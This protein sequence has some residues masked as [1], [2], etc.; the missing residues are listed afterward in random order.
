MTKILFRSTNAKF[1]HIL[2][3]QL[4]QDLGHAELDTDLQINPCVTQADEQAT[5]GDPI[6]WTM[7]ALTAAGA[8]GA[9]TAL[10]GRDGFLEDPQ[11][12]PH[13]DATARVGLVEITPTVEDK[14]YFV[15]NLLDNALTEE[16]SDA[17]RQQLAGKASRY[18]YQLTQ[19]SRPEAL[20]LEIVL[21][22]PFSVAGAGTGCCG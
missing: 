20:G 11:T 8:R 6:T 13:L 12:E 22:G 16:L 17:E 4:A 15:S 9:L 21:T 14:R 7:I 19:N 1:M 3:D 2:S 18:L 10:L 5:R